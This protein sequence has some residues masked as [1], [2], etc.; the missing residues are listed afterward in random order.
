MKAFFAKLRV[1]Q[2]VGGYQVN[3]EV[4]KAILGFIGRGA[5]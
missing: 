4:L 2:L 1:D 5:S 3:E